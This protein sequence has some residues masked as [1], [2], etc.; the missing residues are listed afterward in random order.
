MVDAIFVNLPVK[1]LDKTIAFWTELGFSF[2]KQ[3]TNDKAGALVLGNN[4]YAMLV[5][6]EYFKTFT[7]K[8]IV[9]ATASIEVINAVSV[10]SKETVDELV[11]KALSLGAIAPKAAD[12]YGFMYSRTF[13]DLDGHTWE[14]LFMNPD[15]V[16]KE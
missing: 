1:D 14:V 2:N 15:H 12:D 16:E 11:E 10:G 6:E 9:D 3:F 4:I 7:K 13:Y 8:E 5:T